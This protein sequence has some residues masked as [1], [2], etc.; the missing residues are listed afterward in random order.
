[1][2][3]IL[4]GL[5]LLIL[6]SGIVLNKISVAGRKNEAEVKNVLSVESSEP[7][8]TDIPSAPSEAIQ[9][10]VNQKV[11]VETFSAPT[12]T[13]TVKTV[14]SMDAFLFPGAKV[15]NINSVE[16]RLTSSE[17]PD[18]ITE[19][20]KQKIISFGMNV[21]SFVTTKANDNVV[22][23]LAGADG[24]REVNIEITKAVSDSE[25]KITV[26]LE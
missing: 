8:P 15:V 25:A 1:M 14:F 19:W 2:K 22:N 20:Y 10:Q 21:K 4:T 16:A 9:K 3:I 13:P 23:K 24:S 11:E 12:S 7:S 6:L 26:L 18:A 5:A 17:N